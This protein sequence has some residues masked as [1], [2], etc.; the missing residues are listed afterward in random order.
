MKKNLEKFIR[1]INSNKFVFYPIVAFAMALIV[2]GV[3]FA[4]SYLTKSK[5]SSIGNETVESIEDSSEVESSE[6]KDQDEE[7]LPEESR[8]AE[9]E[10]ETVPDYEEDEVYEETE[11][12]TEET[13][14]ETDETETS[15]P[16]KNPYYIKINKRMN[17]V[18]VYGLDD[19]D[20]YTVPVR[21]MVASTGNATPLGKF[22]TKVKYTWK[23]LNGG[24]WGQYSTRIHGSILFHS[25]PMVA[26]SKDAVRYRYYNQLGTT[27]SAGC[28]RLT[29]IDAKWIFDNCPIGTTV[30]I[31][32]DSNPG[33]LGKP[34]A[35][36]LPLSNGRNTTGW[37]PTDPDPKNPWK[38]KQPSIKVVANTTIE[39][40][41]N[42]DIKGGVE[43]FDTAGNKIN[44]MLQVSGSVDP[45]KVGAYEVTYSVKDAIGKS[46]TE[47]VTYN[48][49]DTTGP[50]IIFSV[51]N[52]SII[53]KTIG[54]DEA[55]L[56]K[57]AKDIIT[58]TD[59]GDTSALDKEKVKI[60]V[61]T[62]NTW[63]YKISYSVAD[64][65]GNIGTKSITVHDPVSLVVKS[66]VSS[67]KSKDE[68][69]KATS[70]KLVND[71]TG[72]SKNLTGTA[73]ISGNKVIVTGLY[74][75]S[76]RKD[77]KK[78]VTFDLISKEPIPTP[79]TDPGPSPEPEPSTD[80]SPSPSPEPEPSTDPSPSPNPTET[81]VPSPTPSTGSE[82]GSEGMPSLTPSPKVD[83][84][85]EVDTDK[86]SGAS[87]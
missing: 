55:A 8:V 83:G 62:I 58:V 41:S 1:L 40:G 36:K 61:G 22:N 30:E 64:A 67:V 45:N 7:T 85:K 43:A 15:K 25:V 34:T 68:A 70:I 52:N 69:L 49:V 10:L 28:V 3:V 56:K 23:L 84:G 26:K 80:P 5:P 73:E 81:P 82:E 11:E 78:T 27:A 12:S 63:S 51:D 18:T 24:V 33:P 65:Y 20:N 50:E 66:D 14:G 57:Y 6:A 19:N 75:D 59:K 31:Y 86:D 35:V 53:P 48:V 77:L 17:T 46:A 16:K 76:V 13:E 32:N 39:R 87:N 29:V 74:S 21:A 2:G 60:E 71:R 42:F 79:S 72:D 4:G 47:T 37:D 38:T 9:E 44:D 54:K